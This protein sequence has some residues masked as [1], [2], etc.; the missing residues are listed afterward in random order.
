MRSLASRLLVLCALVLAAGVSASGPG[1]QSATIRFGVQDDAWLL[2][3]P[4]SLHDRLDTVDALGAEIVRVN[5]HWNEIAA[6]RPADATAADD[7]AYDWSG[8][9]DVLNGLHDHGVEVLLGIVGAPGWA[10]GNRSP[11]W[12]PTSGSSIAAFA[13]AAASRYPWVRRWLIWNEPNQVR[14]LRPTRPSVY[15]S[16]L[17]NPAYAALHESIPDV[18]VGGGVTAPRGATGG[19]SPVDWIQGMRTAHARLDAYA[20]NPYPLDP[21]RESPR[22]GACVHCKTLSMAT[23]RRL[24][25]EVTRSFGKARIWLSEYGYQTN[26]PDRLLGISPELQARYVGDGAY[27]AARTARVD[28]LIHYLVRDEPTLG[29][30]QSG[31]E[32]LSGRRKPSYAAFQLPLV[33]VSR[34][35]T[36]VLLWG[37]LRAPAAGGSCRLEQLSPGRRWLTGRLTAGS[38]G[39][40][41]WR[42][43]IPGGARVRIVAG[44]LSS[45]PLAIR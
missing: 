42:G 45:P 7:P 41:T 22:S 3:G 14:W 26:P 2:H 35:G 9:D 4:G 29:R 36:R 33:E 6:S 31:L 10:N 1:A 8:Y 44:R 28:V 34:H 17:L 21:H 19:V 15:V 30:F 39:I 5:L 18:Q 16:R 20:H 12:V 40:F 13:R 11:N 23:I 24:L 38:G 32:T 27:Q 43:T 37:Q 25:T